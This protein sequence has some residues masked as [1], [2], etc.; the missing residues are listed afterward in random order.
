[1]G[2]IPFTQSRMALR[3]T[4]GDVYLLPAVF[5]GMKHINWLHLEIQL[6]RKSLTN[7][8]TD[9]KGGSPE[10]KLFFFEG[11]RMSGRLEYL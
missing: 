10:E 3:T 4:Y 5:T 2:I 1:M 9:E 7:K 6:K 8:Y 11:G